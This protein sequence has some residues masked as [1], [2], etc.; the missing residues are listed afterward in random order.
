MNTLYHKK[1]ITYCKRPF[2]GPEQVLE[3]LGRYTHRVA[4]SNDRIVKMD[5]GK[6]TFR[7]RDY[8]DGDQVKQ[9]SLE[10]VEFI[11]RF[12]LHILPDNFVKIRYYGLFNNRNRKAKIM[13]CKEILGASTMMNKSSLYQRAG[14]N[15]VPGSPGL[16]HRYALVVEK[17][18]MVRRETL[19]PLIHSPPGKV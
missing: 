18:R 5:D 10:A 9:I 7:Y 16:T 11:R 19:L 12:L 15:Y 4:I 14:K 3:Y 1:W 17:G 6:M 2:G 8:R 13:L